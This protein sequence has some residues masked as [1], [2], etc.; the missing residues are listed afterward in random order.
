MT[1]APGPIDASRP[2]LTPGADDR[3]GPDE[4]IRA[5]LRAWADDRARLDGHALFKPRGLGDMSLRRNPGLAADRH[6]PQCRRVEVARQ[7][8]EGPIR[9]CGDENDGRLA[10][11]GAHPARR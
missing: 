5:D 7:D 6:R 1:V 3:A 9:R 2:I 8:G 10:A 4:G 11:R